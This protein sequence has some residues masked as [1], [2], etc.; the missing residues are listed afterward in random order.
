MEKGL[1]SRKGFFSKNKKETEALYKV[2]PMS[3]T[4][5]KRELRS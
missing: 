5:K 4:F 1:E 3:R 2:V